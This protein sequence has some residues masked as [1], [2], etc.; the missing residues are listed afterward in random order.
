MII[1]STL[2]FS[3]P[4]TE[5]VIAIL[6]FT[7]CDKFET[8]DPKNLNSSATSMFSFSIVMFMGLLEIVL[9]LLVFIFILY[10][11]QASCS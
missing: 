11:L 3:L 6:L 5:L 4:K 2:F 1:V 10:F 8:M 7:S 9:H